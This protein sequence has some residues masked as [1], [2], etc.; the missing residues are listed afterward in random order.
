[1]KKTKYMAK[2][3]HASMYGSYYQPCKVIKQG[4]DTSWIEFEDPIS[5]ETIQRAER[6]DD[7]EYEKSRKGYL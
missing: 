3:V 2:F 5:G 4:K 6:N 1:M 7:I